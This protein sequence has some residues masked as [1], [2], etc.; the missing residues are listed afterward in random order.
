MKFANLKSLGHNIADSLASGVG[1]MIGVYT[2]D[3][4]GEATSSKNGFIVIDVLQGRCVA[5][6]ASRGLEQA[7]A[8]YRDA[9]PSMCE[10]HGL[11]LTDIA[12][13]QA[14]YGVDAAYG[15]HFSVTVADSSN[16][17]STDRYLGRPGRRLA[18]KR[19]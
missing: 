18:R 15:P 19:R 11:A 9:L 3:V 7:V 2:M 5:G 1:L 8:L 12:A 17:R 14:R 10:K 13:L 4:F 6:E 16:R